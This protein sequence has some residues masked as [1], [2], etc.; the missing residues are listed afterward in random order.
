MERNKALSVLAASCMGLQDRL[1]L[2]FWFW[3][4]Y[5]F[6]VLPLSLLDDSR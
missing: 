6:T 1:K 4:S 3:R 5:I 2:A